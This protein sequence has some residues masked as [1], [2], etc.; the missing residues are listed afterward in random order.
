MELS[1]P[2]GGSIDG[3]AW[4]RKR[5]FIHEDCKAL[6]GLESSYGQPSFSNLV[7][8]PLSDAISTWECSENISRR[9]R[10]S[11]INLFATVVKW[12]ALKE[13]K[14]KHISNLFTP[15][16]DIVYKALTS[17]FRQSCRMRIAQSMLLFSLT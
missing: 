13:T 4:K 12:G 17:M 5:S 16:T 9:N 1:Q 14:G 2:S 15:M 8:V 6:N 7:F 10:S 11:N 3:C